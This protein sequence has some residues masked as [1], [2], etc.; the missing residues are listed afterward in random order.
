MKN[1]VKSPGGV[2]VTTREAWITELSRLDLT[3]AKASDLPSLSRLPQLFRRPYVCPASEV[4]GM[5]IGPRVAV[6]EG[7]VEKTLQGARYGTARR[8]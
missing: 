4:S 1:L 3:L 5:V 6:A 2:R 8:L 7:G